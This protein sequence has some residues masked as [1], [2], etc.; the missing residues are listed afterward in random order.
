MNIA[1]TAVDNWEAGGSALAV[2]VASKAG[3]KAWKKVAKDAAKD[4]SQIY[5]NEASAP[6]QKVEWL[7]KR[8]EEMDEALNRRGIAER[9]AK[10]LKDA[11]RLERAQAAAASANRM[12][13]AL[14]AVKYGFFAWDVYKT[15]NRTNDDMHA[16]GYDSAWSGISDAFSSGR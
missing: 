6:S 3:D 8:L 16:A 15:M 7:S 13:T 11:R 14:S 2:G 4:M 12:G 10:Y 1:M 5:K 9:S